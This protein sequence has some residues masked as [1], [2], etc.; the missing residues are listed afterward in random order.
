MSYIGNEPTSVA[1]LTDTFSGNGSTT[2][3]T[4]SAAPATTTSILVAVTGVLQDPSTYSVVGTTLTFSAAPPSGT[5][6]ISVRY[7]GIPASG[8]TTT[9]YRTITEFTATAGQTT[10]TPPSYTPGFI[11]VYRNGALLSTTDYTATN[12]TTVVL[13]SAASAGDLVTIESFYV[14]S[15]LNALPQTGGTLSGSLVVNGATGQNPLIV[16]N[17]T[18][19]AMRVDS[20]GNVGIGANGTGQR[21]FVDSGSYLWTAKINS[22]NGVA[23]ALEVGNSTTRTWEF[24]V[25]GNT[26]A[27]TL[28]AG[29]MYFYDQTA[30]QARLI[31][32]T[33]GRVTVPAQP[34]FS[35]YRTAGLV[36]GTTKVVHN[37]IGVN[38]GS[39]YNSGTFTCPTA[40]RYLVTV[41]GHAENSQPIKLCI[42]KNGSQYQCGYSSIPTASF[43]TTSV[44]AILDCAINDTIECYVVQGTMWGGDNTGLRMAINLIG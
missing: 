10:F 27:G 14:S 19:E 3:F 5:G 30:A 22:S 7:L 34:A 6:N 4:M 20:S 9:A 44:T 28:P 32:D 29:G 24:A 12:G 2:A 40:G 13:G 23:T 15:V 16:Q 8:V 17:N 39:C 26:P 25:A 1:F 41:A 43:T 11:N 18:T 38:T 21:L 36:S 37:V 35:G 31:I 33:G 42:Y